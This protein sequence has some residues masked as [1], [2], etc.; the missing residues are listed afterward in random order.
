MTSSDNTTTIDFCVY[1]ACRCG[2]YKW[3]NN[4]TRRRI[5]FARRLTSGTARINGHAARAAHARALY[6]GLHIFEHVNAWRSLHTDNVALSC[7]NGFPRGPHCHSGAHYRG[8]LARKSYLVPWPT[9]A[10]TG[11]GLHHA[12]DQDLLVALSASRQHR[13]TRPDTIEST[14]ICHASRPATVII[15]CVIRPRGLSLHA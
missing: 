5:G 12:L 3:Q 6:H 10:F 15:I 9:M 4:P 8:P 2:V 7:I 11:R 1:V 14:L 13:E